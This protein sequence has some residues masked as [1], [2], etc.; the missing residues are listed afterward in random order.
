MAFANGNSTMAVVQKPIVYYRYENLYCEVSQRHRRYSVPRF[1]R[2]A[3]RWYA[4][5]H[6][7]LT[8]TQEEGFSTSLSLAILQRKNTSYVYNN[9]GLLETT[10]LGFSVSSSSDTDW[11]TICWKQ[12][13]T[14]DRLELIS[15]LNEQLGLNCLRFLN[16]DSHERQLS[17]CCKGQLKRNPDSDAINLR[18]EPGVPYIDQLFARVVYTLR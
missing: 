14:L 4:E 1:K 12:D 6:N 2:H 17:T 18:M 16:D 9:R 10:L 3:Y 15:D 5:F 11:V 13:K 8:P 7:N